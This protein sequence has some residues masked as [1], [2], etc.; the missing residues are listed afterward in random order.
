MVCVLDPDHLA[1]LHDLLVG[2]DQQLLCLLDAD[3][4]QVLDGC[5]F[6]IFRELT[7]QAELVDAVF[8]GELV[9]G[10][11][12][13]VCS[14]KAAVHVGDVGRDM[15]GTGLLDSAHEAELREEADE[16]LGAHQTVDLRVGGISQDLFPRCQD[17]GISVQPVD[18]ISQAVD[19]LQVVFQD[20]DAHETDRVLPDIV[21]ADQLVVFAAVDDCQRAFCEI[22]AGIDPAG[23]FIVQPSGAAC[24]VHDTERAEVCRLVGERRCDGH[25]PVA[26]LAGEGVT[27]IVFP[28]VGV[29]KI[30]G[31]GEAVARLRR[32]QAAEKFGGKRFLRHR[33][34]SF[35]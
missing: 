13:M 35:G 34:H 16:F 6:I 11:W 24:R 29:V 19:L 14:G 21:L 30:V 8:E 5:V 7:A 23:I 33:S 18:E 2:G 1:D 25:A 20:C 15:V 17:I 4:V 3:P 12:F 27:E 26:Q 31:Q 32:D 22:V 9:E 10:V 28:A